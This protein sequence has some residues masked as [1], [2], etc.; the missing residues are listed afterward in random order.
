MLQHNTV[1][2]EKDRGPY[3]SKQKEALSASRREQVN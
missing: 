1:P 3:R 2:E